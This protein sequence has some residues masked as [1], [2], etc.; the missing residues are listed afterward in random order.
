LTPT[1]SVTKCHVLSTQSHPP[2]ISALQGTHRNPARIPGRDLRFSARHD[3]LSMSSETGP[4]DSLE[5]SFHGLDASM[6]ANAT[7]FWTGM[8]LDWSGTALD[9]NGGRHR[10]LACLSANLAGSGGRLQGKAS[11][12][13][14]K[15]CACSGDDRT[16]MMIF[17]PFVLRGYAARFAASQP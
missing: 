14:T 12:G 9:D 10:L 6:L 5:V 3:L 4:C 8:V 2:A 16:S 1:R 13:Y 17:V 7:C 11:H 15:C